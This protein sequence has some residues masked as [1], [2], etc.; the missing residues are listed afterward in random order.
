[1]V[2]GDIHAELQATNEIEIMP[3]VVDLIGVLA[4]CIRTLADEFGQVFVPCVR[5]VPIPVSTG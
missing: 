4:W 1:M 3:T 5:G 2:S